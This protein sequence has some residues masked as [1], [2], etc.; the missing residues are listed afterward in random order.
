MTK[1]AKVRMQYPLMY[2]TVMVSN[3][4]K[5]YKRENLD[6]G[7]HLVYFN[8]DGV[9]YVGYAEKLTKWGKE[10]GITYAKKSK[11][12]DLE[13]EYAHLVIAKPTRARSR[14]K[15]PYLKHKFVRTDVIKDYSE[16]YHDYNTAMKRLHTLYSGRELADKIAE[17]K[18]QFSADKHEAYKQIKA[19]LK[20]GE[21]NVRLRSKK[22]EWSDEVINEETPSD[23]SPRVDT[24]DRFS[25]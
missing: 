21:G 7:N 24:S 3:K 16:E 5:I 19:A 17:F 1:T 6:D 9:I 12:Q 13:D 18:R 22:G 25:V 2:D 23:L 4:W 20:N 11:Q 14:K 15:I 10:W 8:V